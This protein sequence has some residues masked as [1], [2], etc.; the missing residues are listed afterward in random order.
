MKK[1][2]WVFAISLLFFT[3]VTACQSA[4]QDVPQTQPEEP[5]APVEGAQD[6]AY[7]G[8]DESDPVEAPVVDKEQ[9]Y[10]EPNPEAPVEIFPYEISPEHE[11]SPVPEDAT[12]NQGNVFINESGI[13]MMESYPVQV[14]LEL[15]GDLPT[16]CNDL[17]VVVSPPDA[18]NE[19]QVAVYSVID[20]DTMCTQVLAPF[21]ATIPIGNFTTGSY[22]VLVNGELAGTID[23]P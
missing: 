1:M 9:S 22:R 3:L 5:S 10:P 19:I 4:V 2:R 17:R 21:D 15:S 13:I 20:P 8:P 11:Y 7:P 12:L 14:R 6:E 18:N 23:L 16:P